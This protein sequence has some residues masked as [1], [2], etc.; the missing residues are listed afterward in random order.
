MTAITI[1][2]KRVAGHRF[3]AL[4]DM[5]EVAGMLAIALMTVAT[6]NVML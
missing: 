6:I 5:V 4:T 3:A 2:T 1:T